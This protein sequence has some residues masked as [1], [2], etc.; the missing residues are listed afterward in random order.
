MFWFWWILTLFVITEQLLRGWR[1]GNEI[2]AFPTLVSFLW[3]YIYVFLPFIL[4]AEYPDLFLDDQWDFFQLSAF[5]GILSL[6]VGWR[7]VFSRK[8]N[9]MIHPYNSKYDLRKLQNISLFFILVGIAGFQSFIRSESGYQGASGYWYLLFL[10]SYPAVSICVATMSLS[11]KLRSPLVWGVLILF[12]LL[13]FLPLLNGTRRGPTYTAII[14]VVAGYSA[15]RKSIP[16]FFIVSSFSLA[17]VLMLVLLFIRT[18]A[19][20]QEDGFRI[21]DILVGRAQK[22]SDNE[23][24]NHCQMIQANLDTGLYQ[25]GTTHLGIFLNWIPRQIWP[26]KPG[27]SVGFF[28]EAFKTLDASE[29]N[30][31]GFGGS[32]GPVADAF[33]NYWY[34][35]PVFLMAVGGVTALFFRRVVATDALNWKLHNVG[36][37]AASH[38]FVA[39]CFTEA[40]VPA[41]IFQGVLFA[42]FRYAKTPATINRFGQGHSMVRDARVPA[43][44]NN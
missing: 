25:Y 38:W 29:K 32:W 1:R 30:N 34:F 14:S 20:S 17:G 6:N 4:Y 8:S 27:R 19:S 35:F 33:N 39:Q 43:F 11:P 31:L 22:L 26:D 13:L 7:I 42:C 44:G 2:L 3:G 18:S 15:V 24:Y 37:L 23:Y 9:S 36:L 40:A 5:L 16:K 12:C 21:Q 10:V 28:P 41:L